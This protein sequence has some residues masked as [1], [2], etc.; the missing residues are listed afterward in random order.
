MILRDVM[1]TDVMTVAP[2]DTV[3]SAARSMT[4][5]HIGSACVVG[6]SG[7]LLGIITERDVLRAAASGEDLRA[8]SVSE[9]MTSEVVTTGPEEPPSQVAA[10]MRQQRFRHVPICEAGQLV[11][12]V[13]LRDL[14]QFSFLPSEPEDMTMR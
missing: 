2:D 7:D 5:R 9:W 1:T 11:G 10:T 6:E 14:W 3:T 4:E 8:Q 13:S 12:I